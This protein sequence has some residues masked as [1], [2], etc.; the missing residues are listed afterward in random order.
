VRTTGTLTRVQRTKE[1]WKK[2]D[3]GRTH[4]YED[5]AGRWDPTL[6]TTLEED[7]RNTWVAQETSDGRVKHDR[8]VA[9]S[10]F[11]T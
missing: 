8:T 9:R 6:A 10:Q 3:Q 7:I 4:I 5:C 11:R 1:L 2:S